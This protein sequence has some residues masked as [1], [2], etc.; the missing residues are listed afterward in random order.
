MAGTLEDRDASVPPPYVG[1]PLRRTGRL[2]KD[3]KAATVGTEVQEEVEATYE[4]R[5]IVVLRDNCPGCKTVVIVNFEVTD[6]RRKGPSG[7]A[8]RGKPSASNV[9]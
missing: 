6:E 5:C 2:P 8:A 9:Q 3:D 7:W 1:E 4:M